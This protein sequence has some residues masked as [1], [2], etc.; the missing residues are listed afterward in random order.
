[1][2]T[3]LN[4]MDKK[5]NF[6]RA[7]A[8]CDVPCGIY[9]PIFAQIY[10]LTVVR[11]VDLLEEHVK[12]KEKDLEYYNKMSR[13]IENKEE[14]AE[15]TKHEIRIIWGD[16]IKP[17]HKEKYPQIDN[18]V[19]SIMVLASESRQHVSKKLALELVS[20]VNEFAEIFWAIK[21]EKTIRAKA[22]YAPNLELV[23]RKL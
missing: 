6:K 11:M 5:L 12:I 22:P 19:H 18:L 17:T 8:H 13:L 3:L 14:H 20:K 1:M 7:K 15:K 2:K 10:A 21:G 16:F 23:Y 9:D 4:K